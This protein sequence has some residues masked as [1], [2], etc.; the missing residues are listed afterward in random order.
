M[1]AKKL[2]YNRLG[3]LLKS[4][5]KQ[6]KELALR[7]GLSPGGVSKA[8]E[9]N[10]FRGEDLP[11]MA[12]FFELTTNEFVAFLQGE[13]TSDNKVMEEQTGYAVPGRTLE[14]LTDPFD[15]VR[16]LMNRAGKLDD[17]LKK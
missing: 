8:I 12:E 4:Q 3:L 6:I 17:I 7:L 13:N 15:F 14:E 9:K 1:A 10:S 16:A 2:S 5:G 11:L